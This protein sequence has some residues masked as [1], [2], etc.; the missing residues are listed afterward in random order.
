MVKPG[1]QGRSAEEERGTL[2]DGMQNIV[3]RAKA[4]FTVTRLSSGAGGGYL[5][6]LNS[7]WPYIIKIKC[8]SAWI[9]WSNT[10]M[11][12]ALSRELSRRAGEGRELDCGWLSCP[13]PTCPAT[14]GARD[15]HPAKEVLSWTMKRQTPLYLQGIKQSSGAKAGMNPAGGKLLFFRPHQGVWITT[16]GTKHLQK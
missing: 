5:S 16:L 9:T 12:G 7:T 1:G 10:T 13:L 3:I 11:D 14:A 8:R 15:L 2:E 4:T 6:Q